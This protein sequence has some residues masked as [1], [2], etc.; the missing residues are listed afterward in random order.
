MI[1]G[2]LIFFTTILGTIYS[3]NSKRL[4]KLSIGLIFTIIAAI[5]IDN[6]YSSQ[7][8]TIK[9][10]QKL[11][12]N[13]EATLMAKEEILDNYIGTND[14]I[15]ITAYP[16]YDGDKLFHQFRLSNNS[17]TPIHDVT[18]THF[19]PHKINKFMRDGINTV[20]SKKLHKR[21]RIG[22]MGAQEWIDFGDPFEVEEKEEIYYRFFINTRHG[23][24]WKS[25]IARKGNNK[26]LQAAHKTW[27]N[28]VTGIDTITDPLI[29]ERFKKSHL[30]TFFLNVHAF[31]VL[32]QI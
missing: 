20:E 25:Y 19:P 8:E 6:E 9:L 2:I 7:Q 11:V 3:E 30:D 16:I 17:Y 18:V 1:A 23:L 10:Q 28:K 29:K 4:T 12:A 15:S 27:K 13:L 14:K 26:F 24:Y 32:R 21:E 5:T 22:Y 31:V